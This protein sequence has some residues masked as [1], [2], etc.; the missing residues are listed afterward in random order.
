MTSSLFAI[1]ILVHTYP[2]T[3]YFYLDDL[4]SV[5]LALG[6][7]QEYSIAYLIFASEKLVHGKSSVLI[8]YGNVKIQMF[9]TARKEYV[10]I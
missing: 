9:I 6:M 1:V 10:L 7:R 2:F 4:V 3:V 5:G 8:S